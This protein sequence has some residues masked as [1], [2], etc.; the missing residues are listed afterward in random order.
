MDSNPLPAG[1]S[2]TTSQDRALAGIVV[3]SSDTALSV[4]NGG[5]SFN[6]TAADLMVRND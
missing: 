6:E 5:R 2:E 3:T 1:I 4:E